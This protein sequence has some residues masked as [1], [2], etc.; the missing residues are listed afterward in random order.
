MPRVCV[1]VWGGGGGGLLDINHARMCVSESEG[2][3]CD[4][5]LPN[6]AQVANSDFEILTQCYIEEYWL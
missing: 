2:L 6:E 1:C 5:P 4:P 3:I